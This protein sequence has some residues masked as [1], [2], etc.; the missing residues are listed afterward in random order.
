MYQ[1]FLQWHSPLQLELNYNRVSRNG[2]EKT[3]HLKVMFDCHLLWN[4]HIEKDEK[5][6]KVNY[7][8]AFE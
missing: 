1:T 5:I 6:P 8:L 3:K 2:S 7:N 4:L